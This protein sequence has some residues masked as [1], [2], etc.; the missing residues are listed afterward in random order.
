M[1]FLCIFLFQSTKFGILAVSITNIDRI[2]IN[3]ARGGDKLWNWT[4]YKKI[5]IKNIMRKLFIIHNLFRIH[6][7]L[8]FIQ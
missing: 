7:S 3:A 4:Q 6:N 5:E 8:P 1:F 2:S